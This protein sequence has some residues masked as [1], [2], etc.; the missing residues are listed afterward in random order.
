MFISCSKLVNAP[1][2]LP[3]TTLADSC[4]YYMF[5]GC[6]SLVSAPE[7]PATTLTNNCYNGM[8][9]G[10]SKLQNITC[11]A[12]NISAPGCTSSWI[13]GVAPTGTFIKASGFD[14]WSTTGYNGIPS[15]WTV[16]EK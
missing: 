11:L 14:G 7:L 6:S 13:G 2:I 3:A 8:F 4:C 5:T 15:G 1:K 16:N 12:T 10:C 9:Q